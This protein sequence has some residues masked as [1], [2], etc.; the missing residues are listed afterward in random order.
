M[1]DRRLPG[2]LLVCAGLT[3]SSVRAHQVGISRGDYVLQGDT[4]HAEVIFARRELAT[5][6]P[7]IDT[8][9]DGTVSD[10]EIPP[11]RDRLRTLIEKGLA[12]TGD[13]SPCPATFRDA[14]LVEGDGATLIATCRC[15]GVPAQISVSFGLLSDL[16]MGHRHLAHLVA[17]GRVHDEVLMAKAPTLSVA[18]GEAARQA[19]RSAGSLLGLGLERALTGPFELLFLVGL[20][21]PGGPFRA[22]VR[23]ALAFAA[24]SIVTLLASVLTGRLLAPSVVGPAVGLSLVYVAIENFLVTGTAR[25]TRLAIPFGALDAFA[26][27]NTLAEAPL[28]ASGRLHLVLPYAGGV[29]AAELAALVVVIPIVL[30]TRSV[31]LRRIASVGV[32]LCG[33]AAIFLALP[34]SA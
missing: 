3:A 13:G 26:F 22:L 18:T 1:S 11:A 16:G 31:A 10:A 34:R 30:A 12:I 29:L 7:E 5:L 21:L 32:G 6:V 19:S 15:G 25:R 2:M 33:I 17:G 8:D 24:A 20:L 14:M 9:G 28:P 27:G 4:V 23:T